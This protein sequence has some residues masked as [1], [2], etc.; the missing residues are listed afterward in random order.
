MSSATSATDNK[1]PAVIK[2][3][4]AG[5]ASPPEEEFW[6]H[7]SPHHEFP[8]SS[9]GSFA[10]HALIFVLIAIVG[11]WLLRDND[12]K[13]PLQEIGIV[14]VGGGGGNP[15]AQGEGPGG[16]LPR[17]EEEDLGKENKDAPKPT[18]PKRERL[19]VP[20]IPVEVLPTD[21]PNAR[22]LIDKAGDAVLSQAKINKDA[23]DKLRRSV[24][25]GQG[26]PGRD[27]G[28]DRGQDTGK[29]SDKGP[30]DG[31]KR[32]ERTLRWVMVFDT[33]NGEDYANQ[34]N[35][36]GAILAIPRKDNQYFVIRDLKKRPAQL[37]DED[38]EK[39]KRIYWVD[40]KRE[41]ITPLC[42][43]LSVNPVPDHV[44]AF[45][46]EKL[47]AQLL[48]LEL[49]YKGLKENEIYETRFKVRKTR[50]GYEPVVVDQK[51]K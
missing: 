24:G 5:A 9:A 11:I 44:V 18:D 13:K 43:A 12:R 23:Q 19:N 50:D 35:G 33:Y 42:M 41:S 39:I 29:G 48:S 26:G 22:E 16:E 14:V 21:D 10:L 47:E 36:L 25:Y 2:S 3:S 7:Y 8:L 32:Y 1:K 6:K 49:K 31:S 4:K 38:I 34:L 20:K 28:K 46:P 15:L 30:G 40:D 45:F 17:A 51:Q 37:L 27:G